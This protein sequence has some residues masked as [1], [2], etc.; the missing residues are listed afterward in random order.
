M[1]PPCPSKWSKTLLWNK[2]E[3]LSHLPKPDEALLSP[4]YFH[5]NN[6][7]LRPREAVVV[8]SGR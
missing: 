7:T 4:H 1:I 6:I 2:V 3:L 5:L 8:G